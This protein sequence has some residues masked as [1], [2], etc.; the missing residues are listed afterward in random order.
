MCQLV[1]ARSGRDNPSHLGP[2]SRRVNRKRL[3]FSLQ[4]NSKA[5]EGASHPDRNPSSGYS[6]GYA[7]GTLASLAQGNPRTLMIMAGELLAAAASLACSLAQREACQ[8]DETLFF[9]TCG[10]PA[11]T[12]TKAAI[13]R[14]R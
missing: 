3:N 10:M 11:V 12:D 13:R 5:R 8:I 2:P 9:E 4:A 14:R 7:V 1:T 6:N